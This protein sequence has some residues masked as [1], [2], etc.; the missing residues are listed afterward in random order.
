MKWSL[1]V[2][3][4]LAFLAFGIVPSGIVATYSI[5]SAETAKSWRE[6]S[7]QRAAKAAAGEIALRMLKSG[8]VAKD[9]EV[10]WNPEVKNREGQKSKDIVNI[11]D[12]VVGEYDFNMATAYLITP[13]NDEIAVHR[14]LS[15]QDASTAL[16]VYLKNTKLNDTS[17][18]GKP[19]PDLIDKNESGYA[20]IYD[21]KLGY[22][23]VGYAAIPGIKGAEKLPGVVIA[24][25]RKDALGNIQWS[26]YV[27]A[28]V[29]V[30]CI[31]GTLVI[32]LYISRQFLS[33]LNHI[34]DITRQLQA[35]HLDVRTEVERKDELGKLGDQVNSVVS[36]LSEVVGEIRMATASVSSASQQ[37]NS[38]A[39]QLSQGATEQA[40][41][42][43]EIASSLDS[44]AGGVARNA[45]HANHTTK[46]ANQASAQAE[47]GGEAVQHTVLAMRQIAQKITIVEDIAY[48]T[49][50]LALNAAIEAARAGTQGKGFAV[51]AGEVR[52]LA[53]RSQ[54][55]AQQIGE[56]AK[57]S[58]EV[59]E[60]AGKLLEQTVPMIR[61]TSSLVS[62]I[63]AASQEQ[64]GAIRE[65]NVGVNQLN[66]VVQQNAAASHQLASTSGDLAS[67]SST[68]QH[69]VGFF[70]VAA[71]HDGFGGHGGSGLSGGGGG[72]RPPLGP[73]PPP[74]MPSRPAP[75]PPGGLSSQSSGGIPPHSGGFGPPSPLGGS[76]HGGHGGGI[77]VD[78]NSDDDFQRFDAF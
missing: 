55:A 76:S 63:A 45:Q 42:L 21:D 46:T 29:F 72:R 57:T 12:T 69:L 70:H 22:M 1:Q 64:L 77:V 78:L 52:K 47:K 6:H 11:F 32:G 18:A 19:I 27:T 2:Q 28:A 74:P 61:D 62:E 36:K 38:S 15:L 30:A 60:N 66:E 17:G 43:Q 7:I 20:T 73:P 9:P 23:L 39:Q 59:A 75:R 5:Y 44:V 13:E 68:L 35:G 58:V 24:I 34:M 48:Q 8:D 41:T 14:S 50:L 56:L 10:V 3:M 31:V 26:Q 40:G 25:P 67:Q 37:L 49:N 65:I 53:E 54:A 16:P 33:P 71:S 4:L 51:V